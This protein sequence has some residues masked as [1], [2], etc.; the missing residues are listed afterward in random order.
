MGLM[1]RN[2]LSLYA[3]PQQPQKSGALSVD[4]VAAVEMTKI[5]DVA[6]LRMAPASNYSKHV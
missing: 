5:K 4:M 1:Y 3:S 2:G 6:P